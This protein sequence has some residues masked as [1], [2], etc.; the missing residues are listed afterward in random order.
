[1]RR[2]WSR[3]RSTSKCQRGGQEQCPRQIGV[4]QGEQ[5]GPPALPLDAGALGRDRLGRRLG[6]IAQHLPPDRR[7]TGYQPAGDVHGHDPDRPIHVDPG[8]RERAFG[9]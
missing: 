3:P 9:V 2:S 7:I 6:K 8:P 5:A 1:V 4:A